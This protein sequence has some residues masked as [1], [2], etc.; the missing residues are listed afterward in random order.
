MTALRSDA[1]GQPAQ[2][3]RG[4][5]MRRHA[6]LA[7]F[8]AVVLTLMPAAALAGA[9]AAAGRRAAARRRSGQRDPRQLHR[10]L[11]RRARRPPPPI[12]PEQVAVANGGQVTFR[13]TAA[14]HGFAASLSEAALTQVRADPNVA[15][16]E[17]DATVSASRARPR[18]RGGSTA[19]TS[20]DLPL[21][22]T[23]S[24]N[25]TGAGVTG[26]HHRHRHPPHATSSSAAGPSSGFDAIDGGSADDC[27][28]HG[29][30]VAGTV[31][32]VDL[33][34][35]QGGAAGRRPGAQLLRAAARTLRSSP[36][37]TG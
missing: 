12:A 21:N 4:D 27:N 33:R 5:L 23:Y 20:A 26:V 37:S 14:L 9:G 6:L 36:A 24:Y 10:G 30:H 2:T 11:P 34:R 29:T 15:Y 22:N 16:V 28:G 8:V 25:S 7:G 3:Q 18:R 35:G 32:G 1:G 13:Y 17:A 31:G 19:S